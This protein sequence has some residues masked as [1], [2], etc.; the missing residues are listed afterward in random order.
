MAEWSK[1]HAWK[2]CVPNGT[3]GS[4]PAL[5]AI[6]ISQL[7]WG[8]LITC[9]IV[10]YRSYLTPMKTVCICGSKRYKQDIDQ[11]TNRLFDL[12]ITVFEPDIKEPINES[13]LIGDK[14]TTQIIF[15]G[16][17][18]KHFDWIRKADATF[19]FNKDGYIGNSVTLE[20]G[21]ATALGKPIYALEAETGDPCSNALIDKVTPTPEVLARVL[22]ASIQT[23]DLPKN[24]IAA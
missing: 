9:F 3:A 6:K 22:G 24:P 10:L 13:A 5:T 2:V 11:L 8:V 16:L 23:I 15:A 18:L 7:V 19:I 14:H 12:G 4:N 20:L 17:T 1:A 21:Y